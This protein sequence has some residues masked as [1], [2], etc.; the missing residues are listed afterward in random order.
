MSTLSVNI[1]KKKSGTEIQIQDSLI[2]TGNLSVTGTTQATGTFDAGTT[3]PSHTT[4][5][6][7][8]GNLYA[9]NF[10]GTSKKEFKTGIKAFKEKALDI[11]KSTKIVKFFYKYDSEKVLKIGFIADDT[12][13]YLS[14]TNHDM[15]DM[16]NAIGLLIK[17]VQEL[18][19]KIEVLEKK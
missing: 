11:I 9:T 18:S 5:L 14:G 12:H 8:D 3:N 19:E 17:A 4:R 13:E 1:I 15:F 10:Y 16:Q 6:N 7:Y 2:I